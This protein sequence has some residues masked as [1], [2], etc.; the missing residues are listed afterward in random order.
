MICICIGAQ[1]QKCVVEAVEVPRTSQISSDTK[2][3]VLCRPL[4]PDCFS[5]NQ[6]CSGKK[7]SN[8]VK[9]NAPKY[10]PFVPCKFKHLV[11]VARTYIGALPGF[12]LIGRPF[13]WVFHSLHDLSTLFYCELYRASVPQCLCPVKRAMVRSRAIV[14]IFLLRYLLEAHGRLTC[15]LEIYLGKSCRTHMRLDC[16]FVLMA[17]WVE[18]AAH[19]HP[20]GGHLAFASEANNSRSILG[21]SPY[22]GT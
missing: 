22:I 12:A 7:V 9:S 19:Q 21:R 3:F 13:V 18:A 15:T 14:S 11:D 4:L 16:L 6:H 1:Y 5:R 20:Q 8:N 10:P 2:V 17:V